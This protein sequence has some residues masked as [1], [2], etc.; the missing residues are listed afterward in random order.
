MRRPQ[1]LGYSRY[2]IAL[3]EAGI[4]PLDI[5]ERFRFEGE[6]DFFPAVDV[7]LLTH[8]R[9]EKQRFVPT[10]AFPPWKRV[11]GFR[12]DQRVE[13]VLRQSAG[14]GSRPRMM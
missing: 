14:P 7:H 10:L 11:Y 4:S 13:E 6:A 2:R 12:T 1:P 9:V 3:E 8:G 5:D